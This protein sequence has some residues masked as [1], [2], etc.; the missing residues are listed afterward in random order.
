MSSGAK[1]G[2][3]LFSI[4]KKPASVEDGLK[5]Q[6]LQKPRASCFLG[7]WL[8]PLLRTIVSALCLAVSVVLISA[9]QIT[10]ATDDEL[11]EFQYGQRVRIGALRWNS[12]QRDRQR[13][14]F[15]S[16]AV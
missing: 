8:N 6:C 5:V 12:E 14:L 1:L 11:R 10:P 13:R 2:R 16:M 15:P 9:A 7:Y 3:G 4:S